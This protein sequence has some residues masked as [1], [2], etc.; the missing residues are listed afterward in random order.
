MTKRLTFDR[1]IAHRGLHDRAAG[2]IE[3]SA[4]AFERA[5]AGGYAI[6]LDVQLSLDGVPIVFHDDDL[7]RLT[8]RA[9]PVSGL[10]AEQL[11]ALPLLGSS[12]GDRPQRF[13]GLLQQIAGRTLLQVELKRQTTGNKTQALAKAAAD[14]IAAYSG[15]IVVESFDPRLIAL[16]RT[17]GFTGMRGIISYRYDKPDWDGDLSASQRF[18]LRHLLHFPWTRFDFIS[19]HEEALDLG[20]VGFFRRLGKA[21]TAWTIRSPGAART[22]L[23]KGADQIVFEGFEPG[24]G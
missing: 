1:P 17:F 3:N 12:A 24:R 22:A 21:V 4:T 5:I 23:A 18:V 9:G 10:T 7:E 16:V 20:A 15:P 19:S 14:A 6:E 11:T 8:G 2:I 13:T